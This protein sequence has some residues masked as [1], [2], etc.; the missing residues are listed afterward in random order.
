MITFQ[1]NKQCIY[2]QD[3]A[4]LFSLVQMELMFMEGDYII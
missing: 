3:L 4:L 2:S 1:D